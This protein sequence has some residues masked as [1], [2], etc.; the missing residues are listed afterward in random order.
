M[1]YLPTVAA[2][3]RELRSIFNACQYEEKLR[4]GEI[5]EDLLANPHATPRRSGQPHCTHSQ[6]IAYRERS[7][8]KKLALVHQY[9]RPDGRIGGSGKPD[10]KWLLGDNEILVPDCFA[11]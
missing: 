11:T 2:S 5:F 9:L 4:T 1:A 3:K 6:L 8:N 7:T 10:P